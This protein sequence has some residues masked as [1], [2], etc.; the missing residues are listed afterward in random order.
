MHDAI[1]P[2][3]QRAGKARSFVVEHSFAW[4]T[5]LRRLARDYERLPPTVAS[6]HLVVFAYHEYRINEFLYQVPNS[7][8][9][10]HFQGG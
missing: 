3:E 6:L 5:H 9:F 8:W 7:S 1:D 2:G 10:G 4:A